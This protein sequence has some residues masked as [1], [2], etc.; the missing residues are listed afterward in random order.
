ML[1]IENVHIIF[2]EA[3]ARYAMHKIERGQTQEWR[4]DAPR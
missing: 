2:P 1:M 4:Q 3:V